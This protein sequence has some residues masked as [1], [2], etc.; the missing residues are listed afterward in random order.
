MVTTIPVQ[1]TGDRLDEILDRVSAGDE[2]VLD[3]D[4][5]RAVVIAADAYEEFQRLRADARRRA[6]GEQLATLRE[7][8][9][10]RNPDLTSEAAEEISNRA[11]HESIESLA[12][13]GALVFERRRQSR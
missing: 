4:G 9:L 3:Q 6:A 8:V 5:R 7:Q 1:T 2:I 12:E 10:A 13:R 11:T